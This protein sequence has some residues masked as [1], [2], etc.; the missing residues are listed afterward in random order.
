MYKIVEIFSSIQGEGLNVGIP[1]IFLRLWGCNLN[2]RWCDE[3]NSRV[4]KYILMDISTIMEE[5]RKSKVRHVVITGGEPLIHR[6]IEELVTAIKKEGYIITVETNG[7]V[8]VDVEC[9]LIS[10]SPKLNGSQQ[11]PRM[12]CIDTLIIQ[13]FINSGRYQLKFVVNNS[14]EEINQIHKILRQLTNVNFER[15]ML[16]PQ[17][18]TYEE[19]IAIDKDIVK[20]CLHNGYRFC[21]R[22]QLRIW[23][24]NEEIID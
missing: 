8:Y 20:F 3:M 10:L 2:C 24:N 21:D 15:V 17:S 18:Q 5:I 11:S 7:T 4:G 12:T 19:L 1:S 14:I 9:D 23:R 13:K 22:L 16:M 6:G